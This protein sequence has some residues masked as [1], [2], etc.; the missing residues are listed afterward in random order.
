MSMPSTSALI[1]NSS[2]DDIT[3]KSEGKKQSRS[4]TALNSSPESHCTCASAQSNSFTPSR[5][6]HVNP[7]SSKTPAALKS[8][9]PINEGLADSMM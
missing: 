7:S 6:A 1:S 4:N 5:K 3:S 9:H 8:L 2:N